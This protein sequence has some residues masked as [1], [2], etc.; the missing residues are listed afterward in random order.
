[1]SNVLHEHASRWWSA[2]PGSAERS[3]ISAMAVRLNWHPADWRA[4]LNATAPAV[5]EGTHG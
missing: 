3:L 1:M 2:A 5:P 4:A